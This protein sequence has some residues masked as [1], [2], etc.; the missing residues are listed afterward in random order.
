MYEL[1]I[2]FEMYASDWMFALY[3]NIIPTKQMH[4]FFD[5]FFEDGWSF[6]Y[7]VTLTLMR[8]LQTKIM[9]TDEMSEV[10]DLIKMHKKVN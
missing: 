3:A 2:R 10:L 1:D 7:K 8:I 9:D 4:H 6:F 5:H